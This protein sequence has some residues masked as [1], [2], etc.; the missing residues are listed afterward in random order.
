MYSCA[1]EHASSVSEMATQLAACGG[2]SGVGTLCRP[3]VKSTPENVIYA[4]NAPKHILFKYRLTAKSE[5][6]WSTI[7][8]ETTLYVHI[9]STTTGEGSKEAFVQ[10]LE[11][12]EE[13]LKCEH[14]V[15][16]FKGDRL[17]AKSWTR[18]FMFLGLTLLAPKH[19]LRPDCKDFV[20]LDY[21]ID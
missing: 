4:A 1:V 18:S 5:G 9:P 11:Y 21:T 16:F 7:L 6:V 12:A 3:L 20:F 8:K 13:E 10:L 14:V 15:V 19:P 2:G 17:D